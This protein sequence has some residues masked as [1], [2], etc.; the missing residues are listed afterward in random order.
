VE[1]GAA[2]TCGACRRCALQSRWA[3]RSMS[4]SPRDQLLQ[5]DVTAKHRRAGARRRDKTHTDVVG[6]RWYET[7]KRRKANQMQ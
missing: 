4:G 6:E 3:E 7:H 1:R 5:A 2:A